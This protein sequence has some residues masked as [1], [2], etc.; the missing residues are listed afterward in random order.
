[1]FPSP[2]ARGRCSPP[3]AGADQGS[4]T[5]ER[6]ASM[7]RASIRTVT[8]APPPASPSPLTGA[9]ALRWTSH[10]WLLRLLQD[11][12]F[13]AG[14]WTGDGTACVCTYICAIVYHKNLHTH[15]H[16]L[17]KS[18]CPHLQVETRAAMRYFTA[19]L[20]MSRPLRQLGLLV[21]ALNKAGIIFISP[22][23]VCHGHAVSSR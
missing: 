8:Q 4:T 6:I 2:T 15:T 14:F 3:G 18:V 22:P 20:T 16:T 12:G 23:C 19:L 13:P 7:L 9:E 1:M 11:F 21:F 5:H 17:I 10:N